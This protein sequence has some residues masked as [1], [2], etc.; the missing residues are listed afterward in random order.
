[1]EH[2]VPAGFTKKMCNHMNQKAHTV[3]HGG[4]FVLIFRRIEGPINKQ[5]PTN[6]IFPGDKAPEPAVEANVAVIAHAEKAVGWDHKFAVFQMFAHHH[7][8]F[9]IDVRVTIRLDRRELVAIRR[10]AWS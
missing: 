9:R 6:Y 5:G 2:A 3:R 7:G 4:T 8:P 1:M 10:I